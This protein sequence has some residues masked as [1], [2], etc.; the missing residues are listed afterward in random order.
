MKTVLLIIAIV[1]T[2]LLCVSAEPLD[3]NTQAENRRKLVHYLFPYGP[4][5]RDYGLIDKKES[6]NEE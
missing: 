3:E 4:T 1:I 5:A 6:T 2:A